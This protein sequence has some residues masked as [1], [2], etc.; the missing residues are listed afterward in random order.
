MNK[1]NVFGAVQNSASSSSRISNFTKRLAVLTLLLLT[2]VL[3]ARAQSVI[4]SGDYFLTHNNDKTI[5]CRTIVPHRDGKEA[6][7]EEKEEY[8]LS[9]PKHAGA[10]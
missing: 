1:T 3:G 2:F 10:R 7:F 8:P 5:S 9:D 6:A 4:M